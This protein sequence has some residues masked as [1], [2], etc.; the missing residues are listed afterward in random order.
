MRCLV[1]GGTGMLRDVVR[2]LATDGHD[3]LIVGRSEKKMQQL[4]DHCG[5]ARARLTPLFADYSSEALFLSA[6]QASSKSL[7]AFDLVIV[8]MHASGDASLHALVDWLNESKVQSRFF[9]IL[10]S[11]V[12][13]PSTT[14]SSRSPHQN[15]LYRKVILGFQR[16][17]GTSRWLTD[18]EIS[19]GVI[20]AIESDAKETIVGVVRPWS[21]RP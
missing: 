13:D 12:A 14:G 11:S 10:G 20:K 3:L 7:S 9:H 18:D 1:I 15:L 5:P 16:E 4:L 21:L 8:W 6:V 17:D 2:H 19:A